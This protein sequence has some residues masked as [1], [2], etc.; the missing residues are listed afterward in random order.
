MNLALKPPA[1]PPILR[2]SR[3]HTHRY[4][5]LSH[6]TQ[7]TRLAIN[8]RTVD[9]PPNLRELSVKRVDF[10]PSTYLNGVTKLQG[11][12][13]SVNLSKFPSLREVVFKGKVT[14]EGGGYQLRQLSAFAYNPYNSICFPFERF[15]TYHVQSL[16]LESIPFTETTHD[17][18]R[19]CRQ[20]TALTLIAR[21]EGQCER[22]VDLRP[23]PLRRLALKVKGDWRLPPS[24]TY[25]SLLACP[26]GDLR[27][28]TQLKFLELR[29]SIVLAPL[30]L[31]A[32]VVDGNSMIENLRKLRL[33][34]ALCLGL[35]FD[36]SFVSYSAAQHAEF[37]DE[38]GVGR[39]IYPFRPPRWF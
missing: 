32:V 6:L 29:G 1:L 38:S 8:N 33:R 10:R 24:L 4:F 12:N 13:C 2:S 30:Q 11:K 39:P 19:N 5:D 26:D 37:C 35:R 16:S 31:E 27:T 14:V 36:R 7:L 34:E 18:L 15:V 22:F 21:D 23:V 25:L 9:L 28:L 20:L 3:R 17:W